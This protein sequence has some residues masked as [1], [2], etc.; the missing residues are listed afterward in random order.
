MAALSSAVAAG[1]APRIPT[2]ARVKN[3]KYAKAGA[4]AA[5]VANA[6]APRASSR[7]HRRS[8][9]APLRASA[10]AEGTP[11]TVDAADGVVSRHA[12]ARTNATGRVNEVEVVFFFLFPSLWHR[13]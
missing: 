8:A 1:T 13:V 7:R 2:A 9:V 3:T 6:T 10:A 5:R 12:A 11:I 4:A